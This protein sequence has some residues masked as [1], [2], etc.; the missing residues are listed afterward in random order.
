[1]I[2]S[3][4]I[5]AFVALSL[6]LVAAGCGD[7]TPAAPD[8]GTRPDGGTGTVDSGTA[9]TDS[10]TRSD[11]GTGVDAGGDVDGGSVGSDGGIRS[12]GSVGPGRDA[13]DPFGDAGPGGAPEWVD[14]E[15][16]LD[17]TTCDDLVPC[18]GDV[19][20]T[21]DVTGGCVDFELPSELEFCTGY[22]I[23]ATIAR[24]RGR[25]TF[26]GTTATRIAQSEVEVELFIPMG[27]C[28]GDLIGGCPG[29][30]MR[31][32]DAGLDGTCVSEG[33]GD[34]RCTA[35]TLYTIDDSATY[36]TSGNQIM[37][38]G[39][40]WDYCVTDGSMR[41]EDVTGGDDDEPGII[42]LGRL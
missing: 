10:G 37:S 11:G 15:V 35:Y 23:E 32:M 18:G 13:G 4:R 12:D 25:A 16:L 36:T 40:T 33:A 3:R 8:G 6:G 26:D 22:T 17:G 20:G 31:I 14:I 29:I 27:L 19:E 1:M 38:G 34:C 28:T 30:E 39:K 24:A 42:E 9:G 41:Y 21:W 5:V 2:I 7:S